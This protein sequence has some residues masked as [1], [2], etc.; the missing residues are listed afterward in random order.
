[1]INLT[2]S[3]ILITGGAGF[4]G[5]FITDQLLQEDVEEIIIVDDLI[6]GS[7]QNI[8][9]ALSSDKI[10]LLIGDI[11]DRSLLDSLF[12]GVDYCFHMAALRINQCV[13]EPRRALE[14]MFDGTFNVA[15]A[16]VKHR[17][18]KIVIASSASIYGTADIFPTKEDH[19]PYN[20]HTLYGAAKT[21]NEGMFRSFYDMYGLE[22]N[23]MRYFNVYGPRMDIYGKY[24]EVLIKWYHLIKKGR[25]PLIYGDGKQ[26]MDFVYVEDVA[27]ANILALKC[28]VAD[29]VFNVASGIET[30]L[31]DLCLA[32]LA[33][34]KSGLAP[35]YVPLPD[36]RKKVEVNR[37]LADI[38]KAKSKLGFHP[39]VTLREGLEKLIHWL[40]QNSQESI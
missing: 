8:E 13:A 38:S 11:C 27:R 18:K 10:K 4:I 36:E 9:K 2:G 17:I 14:V 32:L 15:E 19:H 12:K 16:C 25:Q 1:M 21:A 5:S 20:N 37:R 33:S 23:A 39:S 30:S 26:S 40:N 35:K 3:K 22:Y 31:E 34:M 6:R 28:T 7:K 29:D 24:T